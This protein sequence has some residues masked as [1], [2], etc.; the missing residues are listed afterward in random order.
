MAF[1]VYLVTNKRYGTLYAGVTDDLVKRIWEHS[2]DTRP[3][4]TSR[5][6]L[7]SLVWFEVHDS[8][9]SAFARERTIKKWNRAWKLELIEKQNSTWRDL[10]PE[11]A[12]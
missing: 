8:R 9:E 1:Y 12:N 11:I 4:F 6:R 5:Y 10:W 3:G 2:T 7:K